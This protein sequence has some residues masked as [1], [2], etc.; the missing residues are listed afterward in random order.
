MSWVE[1]DVAGKRHDDGWDLEKSALG[2]LQP[3]RADFLG[4]GLVLAPIGWKLAFQNFR[5]RQ[6]VWAMD[7]Q[8]TQLLR[9]D[10]I[11]HEMDN[12]LQYRPSG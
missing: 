7:A 3:Q 8:E 10:M 9:D 4:H 1:E 6:P 5:A 11:V 12:T 2:V